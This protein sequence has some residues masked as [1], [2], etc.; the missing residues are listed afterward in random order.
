MEQEVVYIA[1]RKK[2]FAMFLQNETYSN[3][4]VQQSCSL[5]FTQRSGKHTEACKWIIITAL[6][7]TVNTW[8]QL[9]C[10]SVCDSK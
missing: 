7:I 3:H 8:K 10:P 2:Q 5:V 9:G 4:T 1:G 6:F